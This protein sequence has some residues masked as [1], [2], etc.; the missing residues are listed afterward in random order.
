MKQLIICL[1]SAVLMFACSTAAHGPGKE[2]RE[3]IL[4]IEE[5]SLRGNPF[6]SLIS[7]YAENDGLLFLGVSPN[8]RLEKE[9]ILAAI[10]DAA[11]QAVKYEYLKGFAGLFVAEIGSMGIISDEFKIEYN[12]SRIDAMI[13][14]LEIKKIICDKNG[15]YVIAAL[16]DPNTDYSISAKSLK[17]G[18]P[19]WF[20]NTP[21]IDGY[22][23]GVGGTRTG[24]LFSE[25]LKRADDMAL[26]SIIASFDSQFY[27]GLTTLDDTEM[28]TYDRMLV[29]SRAEIYGFNVIS[30][31]MSP[32][33]EYIYSL[34]ICR[35]GRS[36]E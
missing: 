4:Y 22:H 10:R 12:T 31:W 25:S 23:V 19:E 18:K 29:I 17:D 6:E 26:A 33:G 30:R 21:E 28:G 11:E 1:F 32:D 8:L 2:Y 20:F 34:A 7:T 3:G 24:R 16:S 36:F 14:R 13:E 9:E 5:I 35:D 15:S 27:S